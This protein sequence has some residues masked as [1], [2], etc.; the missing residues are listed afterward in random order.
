MSY[1]LAANV[2]IAETN[3]GMVLLNERTGKY[4]QANETGAAVLRT[5][6]DG[7]TVSS[8][9]TKLLERHP[10]VPADRVRDDVQSVLMDLLTRKLVALWA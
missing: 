2:T 5:L 6:I 1:T 8:A 4:W 7:G 3:R 9:V 10:D